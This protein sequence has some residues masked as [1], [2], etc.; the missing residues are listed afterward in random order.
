MAEDLL[1]ADVLAGVPHG[2]STAAAGDM[3]LRGLP[4]GDPA[5]EPVLANRARI[6]DAVL[7]GAGLVGV[8]Q[9][10]GATCVEAGAWADDARPQADAL[11]TDRPGM[12]LGILT[13]DC[14][15]VLLADRAA[16]VIGAAHA[17]WKGAV[18]GVVE[19]TLA[20]MERLG[21]RRTDIAA[22]IGPAIG[23]ASYEVDA[24]FRTRF[25]EDEARFFAP[26]ARVGHW[27]FDLSGFVAARLAAGGVRQ[28][29]V[30][31]CDTYR[32]ADRFFSF[33]RATHQGKADYGRQ[34]SLIGLPDRRRSVRAHIV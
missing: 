3:G 5:L 28:V 15:P 27:Q 30:L 29:A 12:L 22:A 23:Q 2:F 24:P 6:A 26:G 16:G 10:H 7:P 13:A 17:G 20:A 19:E 11:V 18:G 8:Y 9:V 25:I 21:A 34:L 4:A 31:P 32:Q 1:T 14:A 33:R